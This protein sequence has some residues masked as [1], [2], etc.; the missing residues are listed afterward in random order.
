MVAIKNRAIQLLALGL[1]VVG[2]AFAQEADLVCTLQA[3]QHNI[4]AEGQT[5]LLGDIIYK[6]NSSNLELDAPWD[7]R[8]V[9]I[10][11][12]LSVNVTNNIDFGAG[13]EILDVSITVNDD[14]E[15][16]GELISP[17]Q[18]AFDGVTIP[19]P[20]E[21]GAPDE[22]VISIVSLRGN[23]AQAG[24]PAEGQQ[25]VIN[26]NLSSEPASILS[27]PNPTVIVGFSWLS[28]ISEGVED[29]LN[30][31]QCVD[32]DEE[33]ED[34]AHLLVEEGFASAWKTQG[35]PTEA[36]DTFWESGYFATGSNNGAGAS[37]ETQFKVS[38][39]DVPGSVTI[40]VWRTITDAGL[41]L[42]LIGGSGDTEGDDLCN[43]S[44][45]DEE[46][47]LDADG[48]G[49]V[50]YGVCDT[51]PT[52]R[53]EFDVSLIAE[54]VIDDTPDVGSASVTISY[55]P[56]D[57]SNFADAD[58]P[59]PRFIDNSADP[60]EWLSVDKCVT[61]L[62]FPFVT[63]Q[64]G[65]DTGLAISN[66][67]ED[68]GLSGIDAQEGECEIHYVGT[69]TSGNIPDEDIT[70]SDVEAGDQLVWL[71]SSGGTH[72]LLGAPDFQGYILAACD[73]QYAH[74]YAFITDGFGGGIPAL[75]QG[76]LAL[77]IPADRSISNGAAEQ[78]AH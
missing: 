48:N 66:T 5:E 49:Y 71:L 34:H 47:D 14:F 65:F 45:G 35:W 29:Y 24:I 73:F 74:G 57:G 70:D 31:L 28:L 51:D 41:E 69:D 62:L 32:F 68:W 40:S 27:V 1:L 21:L 38:I 19:F 78:L 58:D 72:G 44:G 3:T 77:V 36:K 75:A 7:S 26:A 61:T 63:N 15:M 11:V 10:I 50:I 12:N 76:Y 56:L 23:A 8:E 33:E 13:D 39:F 52:D 18:V 9:N 6:C 22:T 20:G 42:T 53:E 17:T 43:G 4:R 59:E 60:E 55:Y 64:S 16:F 46:V 30:G 67:S 25:I 37:Q 2:G 54:W